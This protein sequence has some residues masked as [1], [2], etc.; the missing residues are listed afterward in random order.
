MTVGVKGKGR[1]GE[2]VVILNLVGREGV[3]YRKVVESGGFEQ[4][5][6]K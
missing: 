2:R 6:V 5:N 3:L 1:C 4:C